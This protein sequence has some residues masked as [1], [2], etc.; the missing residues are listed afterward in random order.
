MNLALPL[1][2]QSGLV[3]TSTAMKRRSNEDTK[4]HQSFF[5]TPNLSNHWEERN[6]AWITSQ[7]LLIDREKSEIVRRE[8]A[9]TVFNIIVLVFCWSFR[10]CFCSL[11]MFSRLRSGYGTPL[12]SS[13][14]MGAV[15]FSCLDIITSRPQLSLFFYPTFITP[16]LPLDLLSTNHNQR[17]IC[18]WYISIFNLGV[19]SY[20]DLDFGNL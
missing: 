9:D 3:V 6:I 7:L 13:P 5:A 2:C 15:I 16:A 8:R 19:C 1:K 10:T 18:S 14:K 20:P 17:W 4:Y 11:V 12:Q